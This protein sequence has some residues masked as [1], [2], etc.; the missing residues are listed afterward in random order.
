[1]IHLSWTRVAL[2][3]SLAC[4]GGSR[5]RNPIN[6]PNPD[7]TVTTDAEEVGP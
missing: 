7:R 3:L 4:C 6:D 5:H 1:M 2:K